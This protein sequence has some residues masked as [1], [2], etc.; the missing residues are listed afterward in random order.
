MYYSKVG[1]EDIE[2]KILAGEELTSDEVGDMFWEYPYV[3]EEEGEHCRWLYPLYKVFQIGERYFQLEAMMGLTEN[4]LFDKRVVI[5]DLDD[6]L[7]D[8]FNK[9]GSWIMGATMTEE[10]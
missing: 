8:Y 4:T 10:E 2:A 9:R 5:H 6:Y 3:Y 7:K 1:F